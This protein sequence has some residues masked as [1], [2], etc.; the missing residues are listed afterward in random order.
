M[1]SY[2]WEG[3][4]RSGVALSTYRLNDLRKGD[5]HPNYTRLR[6]MAPFTLHYSNGL[7]QKPL[8][9]QNPETAILALPLDDQMIKGFQL[10]GF[11][12]L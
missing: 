8:T 1:T 10:L 4:G 11:R 7:P 5:E 12:S 2:D 9:P 6:S 3:N